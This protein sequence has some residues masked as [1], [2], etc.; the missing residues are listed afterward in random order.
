MFVSAEKAYLRNV[1]KWLIAVQRFDQSDDTIYYIY[2]D[3][4]E[5]VPQTDLP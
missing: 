1:E 3:E 4:N 5:V 2:V